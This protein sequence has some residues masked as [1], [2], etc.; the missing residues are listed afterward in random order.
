[1]MAQGKVQKEGQVINVIVSH[2][3]DWSKLLRELVGKVEQPFLNR[4]SDSGNNVLPFEGENKRTQIR[5]KAGEDSF[6]GA[7]D[8]R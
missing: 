1:M 8:F 6:P 5:I 3:E 4:M 2:C 7:R